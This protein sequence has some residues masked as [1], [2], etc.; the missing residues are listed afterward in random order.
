MALLASEFDS[1]H[2]KMNFVSYEND[3]HRRLPSGL[4]WLLGQAIAR[5]WKFHMKTN[6]RFCD[7]NQSEKKINDDKFN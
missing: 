5:W 3:R 1:M 6:L 2:S 7:R 4:R